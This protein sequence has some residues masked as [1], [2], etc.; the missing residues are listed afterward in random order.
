MQTGACS[1]YK[2]WLGKANI[3]GSTMNS[4]HYSDY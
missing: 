2:A 1:V 4:D 3:F